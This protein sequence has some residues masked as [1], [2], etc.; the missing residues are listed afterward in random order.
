MMRCGK[1]CESS[2]GTRTYPKAIESGKL[3]VWNESAANATLCWPMR[4]R[5]IGALP[6]AARSLNGLR[7]LP[8]PLPIRQM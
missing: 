1:R 6:A 3:H 8:I 4:P 2:P 7:C 5:Q